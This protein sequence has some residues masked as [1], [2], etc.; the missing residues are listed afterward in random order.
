MLDNIGFTDPT[1]FVANSVQQTFTV[2]YPGSAP[3]ML[4]TVIN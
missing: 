3:I 1:G 4:G 2:T